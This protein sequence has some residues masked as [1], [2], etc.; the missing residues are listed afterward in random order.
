MPSVPSI[1]PGTIELTRMPSPPHSIASV[2]VSMSTPAL[3]AHT[4][5][6]YGVGTKACDAEMLMTDAPGLR[7]NSCAPRSTLKLP[8]RSM[9]TTVLKPLADMPSAGA[10]K[11][12]AAP[13]TSTSIGPKRACACFS[14]SATAAASRT[15][16]L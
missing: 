5:A 13:D 4:C 6:W 15:S 11:L 12:P 7:R 10:R 14:A 3:A 16:A 1:G 9:S 2:R 8:S